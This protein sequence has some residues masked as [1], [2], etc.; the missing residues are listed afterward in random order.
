MG[1][2][3][4]L[5]KNA[6]RDL[7]E[8]NARL[9][10]LH[11]RLT[12]DLHLPPERAGALIR[13]LI[14]HVVENV[15]G[16]YMG[17]MMAVLRKIDTIRGHISGVIDHIAMEGILPDGMDE[18]GF[19]TLL[20]DLQ[21]EM[22]NL[23]TV[24]QHAEAH[25][26]DPDINAIIGGIKPIEG[27]APGFE[28]FGKTRSKYQ[29]VVPGRPDQVPTNLLAQLETSNPRRAALLNRALDEHGDLVGMAILA[30]LQS[31]QTE[32]LARLR[33]AL[34]PSYPPEDWAELAGAVEEMGRGYNR[35]KEAGPAAARVRS[36]RLRGLP[37]EIQ[38][39]IGQDFTILGPLATQHPDDLRALYEGWAKA[40]K[41]GGT[42]GRFRD[43]VYGEM[44][45]GRRPEL[46]EWQSA[47]DLANQH[48]ISLLKDPASFDPASP[49]LRRVNPREGGTDLLGIREN[50][51]IWYVDDKSHRL[52]PKQRAAGQ[53]DLNVSGVSAFEGPRLLGN[54]RDDIADMEAAF[55]RMRS[56]G[57]EPDPRAVEALGRLRRAADAVEGRTRGWT[58]QDFADPAKAKEVFDLLASPDYR[59]T[60]HVSSTMGDV[61]GVSAR[62]N[63]LGI[64]TVPQFGPGAQHG[65]LYPARKLP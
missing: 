54:M 65:P 50:G 20:D 7:A 18:H 36:Q 48:G 23:K 41:E 39:A 51:D 38:D 32:A 1:L 34:G 53:T 30:D 63:D 10:E 21:H 6:I 35:M 44:R 11:G 56:D 60:F 27:N 14:T 12:S 26:P 24:R 31:S 5:P 42:P 4:H 61:T 46:A 25:P 45:S 64:S 3:A 58:E 47:H 17:R 57:A 29:G 13:S 16:D 8:S 49:N 2:S 19:S 59:I 33:Q 62:L 9:V 40:K 28:P 15:S 55:Q 37:Q 43:Y 22:E 52:S